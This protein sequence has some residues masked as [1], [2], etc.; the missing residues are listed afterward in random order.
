MINDNELD[1][2]LK[3]TL[4]E[5][6]KSLK[7]IRIE[8]AV[9]NAVS[10]AKAKTQYKV[11]K[12][13]LIISGFIVGINILLVLLALGMNIGT[14]VWFAKLSTVNWF[15]TPTFVSYFIENL[16]NIPISKTMMVS[17]ISTILVLLFGVIFEFK[18][19]KKENL[20][21]SL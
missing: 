6:F 2:L 21:Y 9:L 17:L 3:Q 15:E 14:S 18:F 5:E 19:T 13:I 16:F 12:E 1:N 11:P 7:P 20:F 4:T 8:E 10:M